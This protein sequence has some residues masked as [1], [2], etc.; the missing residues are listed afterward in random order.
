[1]GEGLDRAVM[2]DFAFLSVYFAGT[3]GVLHGAALCAATGLDMEQYFDLTTSFL[4]EVGVRCD[5]FKTMILKRDYNDIQSTLKTDLGGAV[6][7][8]ETAE[9]VG[10]NR[11]FT[12]SHVALMKN[13]VDQGYAMQD[14]A[15]MIECFLSP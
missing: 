6:L 15:A 12:K 7:L 4:H 1:M 3:I 5:P 13:A 9:R 11:M 2:G 10:L 8:A 14:T